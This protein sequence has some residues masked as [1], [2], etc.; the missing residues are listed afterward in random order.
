MQKKPRSKP[1]PP[2]L[3]LP[4]AGLADEQARLAALKPWTRTDS[5]EEIPNDWRHE[6]IWGTRFSPEEIA[7]NARQVQILQD[8]NVYL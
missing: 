8:A 3:P 7:D 1:L 6:E 4:D 2:P 5:Q